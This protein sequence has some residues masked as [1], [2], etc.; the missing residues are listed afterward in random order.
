M[1]RAKNPVSLRPVLPADAPRLAALFRESVEVLACDDYDD[2]QR[3]AWT[4]SADDE[5]AFAKKLGESLSIVALLDGEIA[6]FASLGD[7]RILDMLYVHPDF[8]RRGVASALAD[9][10]EKLGAARGARI[11]S[12]DASDSAREF[13]EKRG[14]VAQSRNTAAI[15]GEW[16]GNTTMT[17]ALAPPV[18][19]GHA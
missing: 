6:G 2:D 3:A 11:L 8:A 9:A 7:A 18:A 19:T 17:K 10:I 14:Y 4:S 15:S 1:T 16:L 5:V 12:V 13:F